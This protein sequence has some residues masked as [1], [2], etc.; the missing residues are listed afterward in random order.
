VADGGRRR[1]DLSGPGRADQHIEAELGKPPDPTNLCCTTRSEVIV[2]RFTQENAVKATWRVLAAGGHR[3]RCLARSRRR[4][5]QAWAASSR[6]ST[7]GFAVASP[8]GNWAVSRYGR[9][10]KRI[11]H[12]MRHARSRA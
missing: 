7:L 8:R 3:Y 1:A 9:L 4:D 5:R 6:P 12:P 10:N 11:E 2:A